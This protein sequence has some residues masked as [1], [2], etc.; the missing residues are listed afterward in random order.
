MNDWVIV[1]YSVLRSIQAQNLT[2]SLAFE[3][4]FVWECRDRTRKYKLLS[5][6]TTIVEP[7]KPGCYLLPW[8]KLCFVL[9]PMRPYE[10]FQV[11]YVGRTADNAFVMTVLPSYLETTLDRWN[12]T[13]L[14]LLTFL[15]CNDEVHFISALRLQSQILC[16]S[17]IT[18]TYCGQ[19]RNARPH[20]DFISS[21]N[22]L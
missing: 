4:N 1:Y 7:W 10:V 14:V 16:I 12:C 17:F 11:L 21:D 2:V 8:R 3:W 22:W 15:A 5:T 6:I 18:R 13:I 19:S 20:S 9:F